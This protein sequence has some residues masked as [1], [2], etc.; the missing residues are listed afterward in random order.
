MFVHEQNRSLSSLSATRIFS[1][2]RSTL[3]QS[4]V[5][6]TLFR[7]SSVAPPHSPQ[8]LCRSRYE[9]KTVFFPMS[10][11]SGNV[12]VPFFAPRRTACKRRPSAKAARAPFAADRVFC[13]VVCRPVRCSSLNLS[14]S[15]G[16]VSST[17]ETPCRTRLFP[18]G[19]PLS[20]V[21]LSRHNF[22]KEFINDLLIDNN[23]QF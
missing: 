21:G 23:A 14:R 10:Q 8:S 7:T 18:L 3:F 4:A 16:V 12:R 17:T 13:F 5:Q 15:F 6:A 11:L 2:V 20:R 22:F 19:D 1:N 9:R